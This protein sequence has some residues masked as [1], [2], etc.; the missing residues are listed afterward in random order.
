MRG[1][2]LY[3]VVPN[4]SEGRRQEVIDAIVEALKVPGAA[5]VYAEADADHNRLDTTVLG[6]ADAVCRSASAGAAG[7]A[8][9]TQGWARPTLSLSCLLPAFRCRTASRSPGVSAK[10]LPRI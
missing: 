6:D 10:N 2:E 8:V 5:L 7:I 1:G 4:F 9:P 3:G